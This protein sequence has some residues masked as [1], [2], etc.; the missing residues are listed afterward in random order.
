MF[1]FRHVYRNIKLVSKSSCI[2]DQRQFREGFI[3]ELQTLLERKKL[4]CEC[5]DHTT[6]S[7]NPQDEDTKE[8]SK[9]WSENNTEQ[10]QR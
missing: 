6:L 10:H 3:V 9:M 2:L 5:L 4:R 7:G 1:L 8:L